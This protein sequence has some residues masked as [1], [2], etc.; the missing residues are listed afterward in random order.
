MKDKKLA[1]LACIGFI[2]LIA[3]N[4]RAEGDQLTDKP[5]D[6]IIEVYSN[7]WYERCSCAS[8]VPELPYKIL[9]TLPVSFQTTGRQP[10]SSYGIK[11]LPRQEGFL[12]LSH[13]GLSRSRHRVQQNTTVYGLSNHPANLMMVPIKLSIRESFP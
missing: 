8:W 7:N 3:Y 2:V 12:F 4:C 6:W 11:V 13:I 1:L 5:Y 9:L 10:A